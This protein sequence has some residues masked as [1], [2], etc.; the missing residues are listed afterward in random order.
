MVSESAICYLRGTYAGGNAV[1]N[2]LGYNTIL[3][4]TGKHIKAG[5]SKCRGVV[6]DRAL[7]Y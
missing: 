6:D 2:V 1:R 4:R 3:N 5:T 7:A